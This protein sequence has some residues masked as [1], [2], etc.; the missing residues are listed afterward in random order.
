M[1]QTRPSAPPLPPAA[2]D[3]ALHGASGPLFWAAAILCGAGLCL[4]LLGRLGARLDR[5]R[6]PLGGPVRA[7]RNLLAPTAAL[8]LG[9]HFVL[10]L[11]GEHK[12]LRLVLTLLLIETIHV[13]LALLN[14]FLFDKAEATTW[15]GH[16]PKLF[17]D[18]S[19]IA[20]ILLGTAFVLAEVW[21][22]DLGG[23]LTALGVGSIVI[24]LALQDT[25]GSLIA[26]IALVFERSFKVG[27]WIRAGETEGEVVEV[28]WRS[29][30]LRTR[31]RDLVILPNSMLSKETIRN[32]SRPTRVHAEY[33]EIGFSYDDPPN[34]VKRVLQRAALATR[35]ILSDPSIQ[36]RTISYADFAINYQ[37]R[38]FLEDFQR[39]PEIRDEFSTR[40]WYAAKRN[41]LTIPF[42]IRT[43]Y[44]TE[45]PAPKVPEP[46]R[47]ARH[48]IASVPVFV[49]LSEEE[50][51]RIGAGALVQHYG[52]GERIVAQ[53]DPGDSLFL[54]RQ[55]KAVVSYRDEQ[56]AEREVARLSRGEFFGEM[57]L[58]TGEPRSANVTAVEDVEA[59]VLS[60]EALQELL[61]RRPALA[62]EMAEIMEARRQGLKTIKEIKALPP[63]A[64]A[65]LRDR[66]G[67][68]VGRIRRFLGL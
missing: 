59:L 15:R 36:V 58:L 48:A 68:L 31:D 40:I 29:V 20:L 4:F 37:V 7:L 57:A 8:Y 45:L 3:S 14:V 60:K 55:G 26:G 53:G 10:E 43:V 46:G 32:Y 13:G 41:G 22:A 44:K 35:G 33:Y 30:H 67:E 38:F 28:T 23:L 9:L 21:E 39:L 51:D 62:Q 11:P 54:I 6:H 5:T 64:Q 19:R 18:I 24:G 25:L 61:Q 42:P 12:L 66:T 2:A 27:E 47:D 56:Q 52:A 63:A 17:R 50:M 34:K 49:P 65:E 1:L 16:V